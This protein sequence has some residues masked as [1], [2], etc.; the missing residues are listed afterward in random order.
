MFVMQYSLAKADQ[1][2]NWYLE[3]V[4][5]NNKYTSRTLGQVTGDKETVTEGRKDGNSCSA[6]GSTW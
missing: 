1:Y 6:V 2:R 3:T 5:Y 4:G